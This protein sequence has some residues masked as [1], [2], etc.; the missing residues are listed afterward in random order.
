MLIASMRG[1]QQGMAFLIMQDDQC[2]TSQDFS[3]TPDQPAWDQ[4]ICIDRLAVTINVKDRSSVLSPLGLWLPQN[5]RPTW[6]RFREGDICSNAG[7]LC[8]ESFDVAVAV[9]PMPTGEQGKS[10]TGVAT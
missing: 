7:Q 3:C 9:G 10:L 1:D 5:S 2:A 4:R 6:E 8:Q